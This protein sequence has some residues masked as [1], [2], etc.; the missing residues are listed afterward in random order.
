MKNIEI[1]DH[2][3]LYEKYLQL[4]KEKKL[5][6]EEYRQIKLYE[7]IEKNEEE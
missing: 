2:L 4:E 6:T 3:Q 7:Q 5:I 1:I